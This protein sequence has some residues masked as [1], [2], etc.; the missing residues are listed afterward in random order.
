MQKVLCYKTGDE[1]WGFNLEERS[2]RWR[3][4]VSLHVSLARV[5][6]RVPG[7]GCWNWGLGYWDELGEENLEV[8]SA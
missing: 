7:N 8:I 2:R 3:F 1:T 4:A 5:A 6:T